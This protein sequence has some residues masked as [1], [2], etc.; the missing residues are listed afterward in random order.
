MSSDTLLQEFFA[1]TQK[2]VYAVRRIVGVVNVRKTYM[3]EGVKSAVRIR[4]EFSISEPNFLAVTTRRGIFPYS[5]IYALPEDVPN[6]IRQD[7]PHTS[8]VIALFMDEDDA[9]ECTN[10]APT[11]T[12]DFRW[13]EHTRA[14]IRALKNDPV[15]RVSHDPVLGF[16]ATF[17]E[18]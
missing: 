18:S 8:S 12:R 17:F 13:D 1:S 4:T 10:S 3:P 7:A 15:I 6:D 2:A 9:I 11:E 5:N 16:P 14:V